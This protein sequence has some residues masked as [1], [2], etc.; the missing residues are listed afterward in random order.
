MSAVDVGHCLILIL[1]YYKNRQWFVSNP[2]ISN[3]TEDGLNNP[4]LVDDSRML[5]MSSVD[6]S[7]LL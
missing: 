6:R 3:I 1:G 5:K 4:S 7:Q 2:W